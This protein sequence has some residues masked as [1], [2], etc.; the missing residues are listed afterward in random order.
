VDCTIDW[1]IGW[2]TYEGKTPAQAGIFY[3]D[4]KPPEKNPITWLG[5]TTD[6][7]SIYQLN[8]KGEWFFIDDSTGQR[9]VGKGNT[10]T[11]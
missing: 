6:Y 9:A 11:K 10:I 1:T 5:K 7:Q 8:S 4:V 2:G 3:N